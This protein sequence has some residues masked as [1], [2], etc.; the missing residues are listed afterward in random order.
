MSYYIAQIIAVF[1]FIVVLISFWCRDRK[2]ILGVQIGSSILYSVQYLLL[3]GYSGLGVNILG[4]IKS[5]IFVNKKENSKKFLIIFVIAYIIVGVLTWDSMISLFPI[6]GSLVY[7]IASFHDNPQYIRIGAIIAS[8]FWIIYN[9]SVM[10]YVGCV[11]ESILMVSNILAVIRMR[12]ARMHIAEHSA[13]E[14]K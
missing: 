1:A 6:I 2:K 11:T 13:E 4:I 9:V 12:E 10:A 3:G 5:V 8:V 14:G 7:V